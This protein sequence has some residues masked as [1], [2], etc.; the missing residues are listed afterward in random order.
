MAIGV[1]DPSVS[2]HL[3]I[4]IQNADGTVVGLIGEGTSRQL[5]ANWDSPFEQDSAGAKHERLGGFI[6]TAT[7]GDSGGLTSKGTL[8]STQVW[9]GNQPLTFPVVLDF[10]AIDDADAEVKQAVILLEKMGSPE[11]NQVFPMGRSPAMASL[12]VGRMIM[13]PECHIEDV[14]TD[15]DGPIDSNGNPLRAT[16]S[17]TVQTKAMI[18]G[19][20]IAN[21]FL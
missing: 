9:N 10:Y 15:L 19:S 3:K 21:T 6:Q 12:Q 20:E 13:Y 5:T 16:V 4:R 14:N 17:M 1:N 7:G 11:V 2:E 8:Q 18:N